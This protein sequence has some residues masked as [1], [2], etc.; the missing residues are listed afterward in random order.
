MFLILNLNIIVHTY[1]YFTVLFEG[2][3]FSTC[4]AEQ[5]VLKPKR[6]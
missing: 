3:Y 4:L 1:F 6:C 5:Y 2:L